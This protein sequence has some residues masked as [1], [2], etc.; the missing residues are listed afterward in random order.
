ME[1]LCVMD[2]RLIVINGHDGSVRSSHELPDPE[3]HDCII[4][5]NLTG[6]PNGRDFILK[7]RYHRMWAMDRNFNML[8]T[9]EGNPGHFPWAYDLDGDGYDEVM[10]GYTAGP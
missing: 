3:A 8:W 9:H 10:A 4:I 2:S 1:V 6:N 7:D 5:A